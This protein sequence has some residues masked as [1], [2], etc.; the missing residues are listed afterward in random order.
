L[1]YRLLDYSWKYIGQR[2]ALT[3]KQAKSRFYYGMHQAHDELL[4]DRERRARGGESE[5]WN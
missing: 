4:A 2:L 5:Q 1:H 3:E